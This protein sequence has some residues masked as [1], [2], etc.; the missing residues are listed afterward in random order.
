MKTLSSL[1]LAGLFLLLTTGCPSE[2]VPTGELFVMTQP[3]DAVVEVNGEVLGTTPLQDPLVP[4]GTL[5]VQIRKDGYHDVWKTLNLGTGQRLVEEIELEPIQGLVLI[6]SNPPG[7][8]VTLGQVSVGTT[9]L[10]LHE[11]GRGTHRARLAM[12]G[13]DTKEIEFEVTDRIPKALNVDMISNSGVL[14]VQSV[15]SGATVFVDGRNEGRT[16]L[17]VARVGRGERDITLQLSGYETVRRSVVIESAGTAR[18]DVTMDL[19]PGGLTVISMPNA[20]RVYINGEYA[21]DAPL[22]LTDIEPGLKQVRVSKR[23]HAD[24][25]RNVN[26]GLGERVIEEFELERNSG[27]L[28]IV[29]RPANVKVSING[30]FM[31]T[32]EVGTDGSDVISKP[33]LIELISQGSHTLQLVREGYEFENKRFFIRKDEITALDETLDRKFIPNVLLRI[34]RGQDDVITGVLIRRFPD[35]SV[36]IETQKGIFRNFTSEEFLSI[37]PLEQ[38]ENLEDS[39]AD[40]AMVP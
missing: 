22:Q 24:V 37:E 34:G 40:P 27:T 3:Q 36:D 39:P 20:A 16:P 33:L 1:F 6:K 30:E 31:G 14:V 32:T 2:Q 8:A 15:P 4:A 25:T 29:T 17:S 19:L 10:A 11:I 23:G 38:E 12:D 13:F 5:L 35:G 28:Q 21:G 26:V 9:P 18:V 7:A